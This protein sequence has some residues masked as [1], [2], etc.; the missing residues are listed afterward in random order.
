MDLILSILTGAFGAW[1]TYKVAQFPK[2]GAVRSSALLSLLVGLLFY[3]FPTGKEYELIPTAFIGASFVGMTSVNRISS[4][5]Q[6]FLVGM[7]FGGIFHYL[8]PSHTGFGGTLGASACLAV[9]AM[10][11]LRLYTKIKF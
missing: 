5:L 8:V 6:I 10:L 1:L 11:G 7:L 3:T 9:V 2:M 4:S